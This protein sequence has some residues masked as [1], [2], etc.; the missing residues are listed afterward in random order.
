MTQL[1]A[2]YIQSEPPM[3]VAN[4]EQ[5]IHQ[6][7]TELTGKM[8]RVR[9]AIARSEADPAANLRCRRFHR[10]LMVYYHQ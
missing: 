8:R 9:C 5:N 6:P 4:Q 1:A 7:R 10:G 3:D 2:A